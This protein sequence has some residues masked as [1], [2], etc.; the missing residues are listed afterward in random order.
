MKS[1]EIKQKFIELLTKKYGH[2]EIPNASLVP[3]NDP[4]VLFTT[5][6]MHPIT[7]NLLGEPHAEGKR[8]VNVQRSFR[9]DDIE[10]VGDTIH[11]T[12][13]EMLGYWSLGDYFKET[14]IPIFYEF[15]TS[16]NYL[17]LDINRLY[18]TVYEGDD[19][20][21]RDTLSAKVWKDLFVKAGI[22]DVSVWNRKD[23]NDSN[24]RIFPLPKKQNWWGPVGESGPCGPDCE[25]FYWRGRELKPDFSKYTPWDDSTMFIELGNDV[26]MEFNKKFDGSLVPLKQKNVDFGGGLERM[27]LVS[28][29]KEKDGS[30]P[31]DYSVYDID[32]FKEAKTL[33]EDLV[34]REV[35]ESL[36]T[37]AVRIVLDHIRAVTFVIT[38]G[39]SPGNKD[40]GYVLRRL[41][42]RVMRY[43]KMLGI[44]KSFMI[45]LADIF[46]DKFQKDY[47]SLAARKKLIS[48]TIN[49]EE[50]RFKK[51]LDIG[52]KELAKI[53]SHNQKVSGAT[54][55]FVYES[56]GFP[57][58]MTLDELGL[59]DIEREAL[60]K[61]FTD[62]V[63]KHQDISR[64]GAEKKFK[65]GLA[66]QSDEV[67]KYHTATHLLQRALKLV[68]GDQVAQMGSNITSERLR[69]DFP[70]NRKLTEE[71]RGQVEDLIRESV[72]KALPVKSIVLQKDEA[73]KSGAVFMKNETYPEQ[74]K[75]YFIGESLE[76]AISKEFCGGPHASNTSELKPLTIYKQE[77]IGEGKMRIYAKFA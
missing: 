1:F 19:Q 36:K 7:V 66:D 14:A 31:M 59:N 6:G 40:Q 8:L 33:V 60:N 17:D 52:L 9:T 62:E 45:D 37:K 24:V 74:I 70:F 3:V 64:Q 2:R 34:Q 53:K 26:F 76:N 29:Y 56:Y 27:S 44:E 69:F 46:I 4:S 73:V 68:L 18:V 35:G 21:P 67:V 13:F 15:L 75:I 32:L 42:R 23:F 54:A 38:D 55:F 20:V 22:T 47:P 50:T 12:F 61:E 43:S 28:E 25:V 65:G 11:C 63:K 71:E 10:V 16:P 58:E 41:I 48:E 57:I 72:E 77:S 30:V 5:A 39:V 51:T 49:K